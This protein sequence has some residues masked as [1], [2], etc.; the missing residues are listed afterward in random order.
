MHRICPLGV[1]AYLDKS[2]LFIGYTSKPHRHGGLYCLAVGV[3]PYNGSVYVVLSR[4]IKAFPKSGMN[5]ETT[6]VTAFL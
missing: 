6:C 1:L 4:F 3:I 5:R 2:P